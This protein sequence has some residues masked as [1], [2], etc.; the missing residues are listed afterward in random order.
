MYFYSTKFNDYATFSNAK[1]SDSVDF[2]FTKF[3]DVYF[4]NTKFNKITLY[5]ADFKSMRIRWNDIK[6]ALEYDGATYLQIIKN[7][8]DLEQFEDADVSYYQYRKENPKNNE[9]L[10]SYLFDKIQ[11]Y[12]CGYG[13][14]PSYTIG[15]SVVM[16]VV[17]AI[18]YWQGNGISRSKEN[19]ENDN[20]NVSLRDSF[21]FSAV[22]FTIGIVDL[23]PVGRYR[24]LFAFER[25]VGWFLLALFIVT[26][27]RVMIRP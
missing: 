15:V 7:F 18:V 8:R 24:Y 21:Y 1:F 16:I 13:V 25:L 12:T 4:S 19:K 23:H 17:F 11:R 27:T 10:I 2:N 5:D 14:K 26:L 9:N 6:D 3:N 22:A 20:L